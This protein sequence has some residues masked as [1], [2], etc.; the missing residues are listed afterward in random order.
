MLIPVKNEASFL[1]DCLEDILC[2]TITEIELV[3]VDDG[4]N[5]TTAE[6]L[7]AFVPYQHLLPRE[8]KIPYKT[9]TLRGVYSMAGYLSSDDPLYFV[10]LLNQ[11]KNHRE[12]IRDILLSIDFSSF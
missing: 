7:K 4:S 2:Q 1:S 8:K 5:D 6:L 9:G 11:K 12:K 3:I 10:I